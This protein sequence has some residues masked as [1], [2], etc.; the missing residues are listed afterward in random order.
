MPGL[1]NIE[2]LSGW[3]GLARNTAGEVWTWGQGSDG[4]SGDGTLDS[5]L[6]P[7]RVP[8]LGQITAI[9]AGESHCMA[10]QSNG[11]VW[12]W[13]RDDEG[14]VGDGGTADRT[15]P[16]EVPLPAGRHAVGVGAGEA[17]S[18]AILG[19]LKDPSRW[20]ST[21]SQAEGGLRPR[22]A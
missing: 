20:F 11:T 7:V 1:S 10:L 5:H 2:Q 3:H 8:G 16:F 17:W 12:A 22:D 13:G 18:F 6:T 4:E 21:V 19:W 14:Q 9:A 15:T